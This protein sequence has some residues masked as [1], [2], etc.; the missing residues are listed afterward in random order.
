MDLWF[1][2]TCLGDGCSGFYHQPM[3]FPCPEG[4]KT[5]PL[6]YQVTLIF[7]YPLLAVLNDVMVGCFIFVTGLIPGSWEPFFNPIRS[8]RR[9]SVD[10][11]L[12]CY[13]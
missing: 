2:I 12:S 11:V 9:L 10:S 6:R 7:I 1:D 13:C 5:D 4:V 8:R 3:T